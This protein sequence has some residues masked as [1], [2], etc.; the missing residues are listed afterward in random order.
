M[1]SGV[2]Q[3]TEVVFKFVI[4]CLNKFVDPPKVSYIQFMAKKE[5]VEHETKARFKKTSQSKRRPKLSSM[6][7]SKKRSYKKYR[8]QG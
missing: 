5:I 6:N 7:K 2:I 8:S 1:T 4:T 3:A